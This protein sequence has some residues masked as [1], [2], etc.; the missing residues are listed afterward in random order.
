MKKYQSHANHH[1]Q[2][3]KRDINTV[4]NRQQYKLIEPSNWA[5]RGSC[6]QCS[7]PTCQSSLGFKTMCMTQ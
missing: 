5:N 6:S 3:I 7:L 2:L 1:V 4:K